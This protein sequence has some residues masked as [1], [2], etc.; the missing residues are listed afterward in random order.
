MIQI[1]N[2]S[3]SYTGKTPY[4]LQ[5][6]DL[7]IPKGA[8]VS[9]LGENGSSKTTLIKLILG[10]LKPVKGDINISTKKNWLC[11]SKI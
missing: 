5:D 4:L 9:I 10:I 6:I 1:N 8:Y 3:F 7:N 2:I 11:A